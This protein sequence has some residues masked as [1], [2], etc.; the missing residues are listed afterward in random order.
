[1][2]FTYQNGFVT[3]VPSIY[4]PHDLQHV[5]LPDFFD[6]YEIRRRELWYKT[7]CD[8][9]AMVAVASSA[10][11]KD[12][13]HQYGLTADKVRVV[14][15]AP[16]VG[17]YGEPS[18]ADLNRTVTR[19]GLPPAFILYPA[20]TW[21]HKN[22]ISL[23]EAV[24][25]LRERRGLVVPLIC[26]GTKN[27]FYPTIE[28]RIA[29]LGLTDQARFLG[30]VSSAEMRDIYRLAR[31]VVVPTLFEAASGPLWDAFLSR[32]PAAC[33]SVTSLPDQAGDAALV[34]DPRR[35][36]QIADAIARLWTDDAL[37]AQLVDRGAA[38]VATFTW[39]KSAHLFRA[40]Y[41]RLSGRALNDSD[42]AMLAASPPI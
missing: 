33:S 6:R 16:V 32:T 30:F 34:F 24:A 39:D 31:A 41:R 15:L 19:F 22:H 3:P 29:E 42:R 27:W 9:A 21:P 37:R 5:H 20:Q 36:D 1:M 40:H 17:E 8:Q 4:H 7:L 23:L 12:V 13:M 11:Q 28:R 38:R 14:P 25:Q 18:R 35:P 26:T 2:H 10:V